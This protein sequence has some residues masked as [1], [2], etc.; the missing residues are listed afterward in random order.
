MFR[1]NWRYTLALGV[2]IEGMCE[3]YIMKDFGISTV[4]C[5]VL[6]WD[7]WRRCVR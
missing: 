5:C 6:I 7:C 4:I 3:S 1:F 2:L